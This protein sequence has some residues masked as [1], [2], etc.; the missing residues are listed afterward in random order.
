MTSQDSTAAEGGVEVEGTKIMKQVFD[1]ATKPFFQELHALLEE[2]KYVFC[3]L[4]CFFE[5]VV[6]LCAFDS[7]EVWV[8]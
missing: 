1:S 2:L 7:H 3:I 6:V 4:V 5:H 8:S